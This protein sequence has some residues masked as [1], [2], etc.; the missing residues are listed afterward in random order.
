MLVPDFVSLGVDEVQNLRFWVDLK[1]GLSFLE[2][3]CFLLIGSANW[4]LISWF[5][6]IGLVTSFLCRFGSREQGEETAGSTQRIGSVFDAIGCSSFEFFDK[7]RSEIRIL[8]LD[9]LQR[10][11][12]NLFPWSKES[13]I[14]IRGEL[15]RHGSF[16]ESCDKLLSLIDSELR[17]NRDNSFV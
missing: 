5:D 15:I 7:I 4:G 14:E 2:D 10:K 11:L 3:E 13:C 6:N 9:F 16:P 1:V 8:L 17:E 12:S